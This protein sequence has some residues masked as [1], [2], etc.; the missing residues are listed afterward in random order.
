MMFMSRN[1]AF[2]LIELLVVIA[3]IAILAAILFPV[4]AQAKLAAK[5]TSSISNV[6]QIS[7]AGAMYW[8]DNDDVTVPLFSFNPSD[9]SI[10]STQGFYY[11]PMKVLPYTKNEDVFHCPMDNGDDPVVDD[12]QGH[13]RFDKRNS[14]Y[15]YVFGANPSYGYN[16]RYL[17]TS[18]NGPFGPEYAGIS[19]TSLDDISGTIQFAAATMKDKSNPNTGQTITNPIGYSRVEPPFGAPPARPGWNA[20]PS[21]DARSQGQLWPRF[22]KDKIIIGWLDGHVKFTPMSTIRCAGTTAAE[23]DCHWNGLQR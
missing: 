10:P 9:L 4:F 20:Y 16:Y 2:T 15:Y 21:T 1:R 8:N 14:L 7:L 17:N 22:S 13:G 11:W 12:A 6:K 23:V 5:K 3:I 19:A 18:V